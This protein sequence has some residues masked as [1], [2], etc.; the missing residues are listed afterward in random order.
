[1]SS[2][3]IRWLERLGELVFDIVYLPGAENV[4]ADALLRYGFERETGVV[5][6][7]AQYSTR[8]PTVVAALQQW[9]AVVAPHVML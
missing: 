3:Q 1:M 7:V 9:L 8:D 4:T 5:G 6:A 2:R